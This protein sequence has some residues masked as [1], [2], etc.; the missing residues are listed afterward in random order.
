[1]TNRPQPPG[2]YL[3]PDL[4]AAYAA[5]WAQQYSH[6]SFAFL[7]RFSDLRGERLAAALVG[8]ADALCELAEQ[9]LDGVRFAAEWNGD[10]AA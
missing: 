2:R 3:D 6:D 7:E 5:G 4:Q 9:Q 10:G 8:A 1:M